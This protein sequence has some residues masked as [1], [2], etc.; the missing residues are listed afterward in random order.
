[1]KIIQVDVE[2]HRKMGGNPDLDTSFQ[3]LKFFLE[4]DEELAKIEKDY[5]SGKQGVIF[6]YFSK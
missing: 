2:T 3:Y 5:R 6:L 4:D 1:M